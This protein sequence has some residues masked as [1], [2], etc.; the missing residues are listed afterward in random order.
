MVKILCC[1]CQGPGFNF[2]LGNWFHKPSQKKKKNVTPP[3]TKNIF[4]SILVSNSETHA[5]KLITCAIPAILKYERARKK[6]QLG[7][8][9]L[10][11]LQWQYIE[12]SSSIDGIPI[13]IVHTM[14]FN[15]NVRVNNFK[16]HNT[17]KIEYK[18]IFC[19]AKHAPSI[20]FQKD[21]I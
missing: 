6:F 5:K 18:A 1:Y 4:K 15:K 8:L 14:N 12:I 3:K 13:K 9:G 11:P 21:T 7:R 17:Y 10:I 2:W 20:Y 16:C 19:K